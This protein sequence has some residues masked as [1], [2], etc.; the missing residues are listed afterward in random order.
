M[1]CDNLSICMNL[2]PWPPIAL[3][4]MTKFYMETSSVSPNDSHITVSYHYILVI[5]QLQHLIFFLLLY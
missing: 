2:L 4:A 5:F 1:L 3:V